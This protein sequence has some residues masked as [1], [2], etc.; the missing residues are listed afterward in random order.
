MFSYYEECRYK[1]LSFLL[2]ILIYSSYDHFIIFLFL[3][4]FLYI[5]WNKAA[6]LGFIIIIAKS[7][8]YVLKQAN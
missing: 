5:F 8:T 7:F 3:L 2:I 1:P 4:K 6:L